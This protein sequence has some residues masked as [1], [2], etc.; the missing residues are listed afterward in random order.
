VLAGETVKAWADDLDTFLTPPSQK[1]T[2]EVGPVS[3]RM[4]AA[5]RRVGVRIAF[6]TDTGVS[7]H[8]DNAREFPLMVQAGFT[9]MDAIVTATVNGAGNL[10]QSASLGMLEAG[11]FVD[12]IAVRQS[13]LD[14]I[15]AILGVVFVMK[16]GEIFRNEQARFT[17]Q[18]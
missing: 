4:L 11:K 3:I 17:K 2:R 13:P 8:G 18:E 6:G 7:R 14:D 15:D 12:V 5:A 16:G 9:P 1:K 10:G